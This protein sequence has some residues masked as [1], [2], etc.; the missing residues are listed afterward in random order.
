MIDKTDMN[1]V[2]IFMGKADHIMTAAYQER[3][4]TM[5]FK[6]VNEELLEYS[7]SI[8]W[9]PHYSKKN[10]I[11]L[12]ERDKLD[13]IADKAIADNLPRSDAS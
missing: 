10:N 12:P 13:E 9:L 8:R 2:R 11:P 3:K 4:F 1:A 6:R 5:Q 7:S